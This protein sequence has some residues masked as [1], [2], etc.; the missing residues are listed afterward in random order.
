[1]SWNNTV[2]CSHCYEYGHNRAGCKQLAVDME[3]ALNSSNSW[4]R[5]DAE[6]YFEKKKR[7]AEQANNRK[8]SYCSQTGHTKRT[9]SVKK[10]DVGV[11]TEMIYG[12]REKLYKRFHEKGFSPGALISHTCN[13]YCNEVG[14]YTNKVYL[15]II[16]NIDYDSLSHQMIVGGNESDVNCALATATYLN[17]PKRISA[18]RMAIPLTV[19]D[20]WDKYNSIDHKKVGWRL[21][22]SARVKLLAPS[23]NETCLKIPSYESCEKLAVEK[24]DKD[25]KERWHMPG[26]LRDELFASGEVF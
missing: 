24:I 18:C 7:K 1:M 15:G 10:S 21:E 5:H 14:S 11:Y 6:R 13:E 8:C 20:F 22:G 4:K 26:E 17:H 25:G 9:C 23:T 3:S 2:R 19:L 12:A 16:T